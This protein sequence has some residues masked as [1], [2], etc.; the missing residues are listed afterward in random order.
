LPYPA[1]RPGFYETTF[2]PGMIASQRALSEPRWSAD[3][4]AAFVL[5]THDGRATLLRL[6]LD[7]GPILRLT[8][9][10]APAPAGAYAGGFYTVRDNALAFVG[11][12]GGLWLMPL[13]NGGKARRFITGEGRVSAPAFSPDG[14]LIAYVSDD[15]KTSSIGIA[16]AEGQDW[17]RRAP[18][19]A[20]FVADPAW[21][22]DG[23]QLAWLE[24]SVPN[25]GWDESRVVLFD[26]ET[27]ER[28]VVMGEAEVSCAQPRWSPSGKTLTFL[29]DK[30]GFLNLWRAAGDGSSPTPWLEEPF[31]HGSPQWGS[32]ECSY[33]W[34][35]D[36]RHIFLNRNDDACWKTRVLDVNEET[37][38][39]STARDLHAEGGMFSALR[40]SPRGDAL[41]A[42]RRG[43][44]MPPTV[45]SI[46]AASG[47]QR[48][49]YSGTVGG[50]TGGPAMCSPEALT[51]QSKDGLTLH[52]FVYRPTHAPDGQASV[53]LLVLIHGGPTGQTFKAWDPIGQYFIQR[54]WGIF[55]PNVRGSA[56][57][58]RA[59]IQAL[60]N[61]WGGKD[62]ADIV[63]GVD[64]VLAR[65][66]ADPGRV[67][68]VGGS[69]GGFAVLQLLATYPERFK[70]GVSLFGVSD[71]FN[72]ART[73][74]RLEAHYL[75]RIVGP[76]P[77]AYARYRD[78]SPFYHLD[79]F[80]AP[81]L[82]LQGEVDNV[83]TK[84]QATAME[85][86]LRRAGKTVEMEIYPG[87]GHGWARAHTI[88]AYIE[89]MER[90]LQDYVLLR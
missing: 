25:M 19:Q 81:V 60:R 29:C 83:V 39:L 88:K 32:G 20:D 66:W 76:L 5:E 33:D 2:T 58:G 22:P 79:R 69:A 47:A 59:Y 68:P 52:G 13:P 21:S 84:D 11:A 1:P 72:L 63:A 4:S 26:L 17:P 61:E 7:G 86:G 45:V 67:V 80:Q 51:W 89:R 71:L 55:V 82:L 15:G 10:P 49:L 53:P 35:P 8:S 57:Y 24:W 43:P 42:L 36:G 44:T 23:R 85:E 34:S 74:H 90:F 78:W 27:G 77:E 40:W 65:G 54:G 30:G 14:R 73:T 70:A 38:A 87:E 62:M 46:D 3:G 75:D 12:D 48:D 16:D 18:V 6:P 41:L 64:V 37:G 31:D 9:D 50:L 28:R 56:G